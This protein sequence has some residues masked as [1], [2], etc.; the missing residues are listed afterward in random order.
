[1]NKSKAKSTVSYRLSANDFGDLYF[2]NNR[3]SEIQLPFYEGRLPRMLGRITSG[4]E[5]DIIYCVKIIVAIIVSNF[6]CNSHSKLTLA[7]S[8]EKMPTEIQCPAYSP[9]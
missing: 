2:L 6:S 1:L 5:L 8:G 3:I 4:N 7:P 9:D